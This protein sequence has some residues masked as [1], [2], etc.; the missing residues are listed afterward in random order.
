MDRSCL[1]KEVFMGNDN[2]TS[3]NLHFSLKHI[4]NIFLF[5]FRSLWTKVFINHFLKQSMDLI[6]NPLKSSFSSIISINGLTYKRNTK[7]LR[8]TVASQQCHSF[9]H[10]LIKSIPFKRFPKSNS[11]N[12]TS[13]L[14]TVSQKQFKK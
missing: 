13:S 1:P 5:W 10:K 7:E 12:N 11:K 14:Q 8:S 6:R 9:I 3:F 2:R 4:N